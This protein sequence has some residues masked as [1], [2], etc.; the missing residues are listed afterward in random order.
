MLA[1]QFTAFV[2]LAYLTAI[3]AAA[4][5]GTTTGSGACASPS[6]FHISESSKGLLA[7]YAGQDGPNQIYFGSDYPDADYFSIESTPTLTNILLTADLGRTQYD[8]YINP[9]GADSDFPPVL[10]FQTPQDFLFCNLTGSACILSCSTTSGYTQFALA[11]VSGTEDYTLHLVKPDAT[12]PSGASLATLAA[13]AATPTPTPPDYSK[14]SLEAD[15]DAPFAAFRTATYQDFAPNNTIHVGSDYPPPGPAFQLQGGTGYLITEDASNPSVAYID[16]TA[17]GDYA[18]VLLAPLPLAE[19]NLQPLICQKV[20][21]PDGGDQPYL[22]CQVDGYTEFYLD[23]GRSTNYDYLVYFARP[24]STGLGT[25]R[26]TT[27]WRL[28]A[29]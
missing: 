28:R 27:S 7:Q 17:P 26:Y 15:T 11:S 12:L 13:I 5:Q 22:T 14:F 21:N 18:L 16:T 3:T 8:V 25:S 1:H 9:D 10:A 19:P 23:L 4:P 29:Y 24:G 2:S 20:A 6:T